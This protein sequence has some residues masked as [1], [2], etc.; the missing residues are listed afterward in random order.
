MILK[1]IENLTVIS[2]WFP[3]HCVSFFDRFSQSH[4]YLEGCE[5]IWHLLAE[6]RTIHGT[7]Y[8]SI[9]S[10]NIFFCQ[11]GKMKLSASVW[12]RILCN[13]AK[14]Q[15]IQTNN[16]TTFFYD[17][18]KLS[19]WAEILWSFTKCWKFLISI[20]TNKNVLFLEK[21]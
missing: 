18:Y 14:L 16:L 3:K 8:T 21:Y 11:D 13:L 19:K 2:K 6:E 15:L 20:L 1:I 4:I 12:F 5:T 9:F 7:W 10:G 17:E